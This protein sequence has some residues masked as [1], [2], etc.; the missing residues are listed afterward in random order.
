MDE[1]TGIDLAGA[2]NYLIGNDISGCGV[3]SYNNNNCNFEKYEA[4]ALEADCDL[5]MRIVDLG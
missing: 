1:T 2:D 5:P 4:V 3:T